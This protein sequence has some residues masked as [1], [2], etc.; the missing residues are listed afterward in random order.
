VAENDLCRGRESRL[1]WVAG[2]MLAN[3]LDQQR[4]G[5]RGLYGYRCFECDWH[6]PFHVENHASAES[7]KLGR[8][9]WPRVVFVS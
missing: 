3:W 2:L 8:G 4:Y 1:R 7:L 6:A 5:E 9:C